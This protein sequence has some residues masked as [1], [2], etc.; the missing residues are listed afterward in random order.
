MKVSGKGYTI[1]KKIPEKTGEKGNSIALC[2]M[3]SIWGTLLT[4]PLVINV[5]N[6]LSKLHHLLTTGTIPVHE[7]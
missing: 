2:F 7:G 6:N 5:R 3:L 4:S 1:V